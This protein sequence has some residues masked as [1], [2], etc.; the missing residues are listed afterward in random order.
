MNVD[1][2]PAQR[3]ALELW[4]REMVEATGYTHDAY[5]RLRE[6]PHTSLEKMKFFG[7]L[8]DESGVV[9]EIQKWQKEDRKSAAGRKPIFSHRAIIILFWMHKDAQ[10]SRY[11][12][13]ARTLFAQMTPE[14]REYLGLP[15]LWGNK[16]DWYCRYWRA[17]NRLLALTEPWKVDR[18][19]HASAE[20]YQAALAS[21]SQTKRDRSDWLINLLV[22]APARRLPASIRATYAGNVAI[23]GTLVEVVGKPNPSWTSVDVDRF[24]LDTMSGRYRRGGKHDGRGGKKDRAG[25]EMETVVTVPNHP[26]QPDSYPILT[27]GLAF[28]Q[29]G[30]NKVGPRIAMEFHTRG[31][32]ERGLILADR[33]Y[34]G[35]QVHR[36]QMP[37]RQMGF[38]HVF[39]YKLKESGVQGYVD[40]VVFIAGRPY[41]KW[42]PED[43]RTVRQ[44]WKAGRI[45]KETYKKRLATQAKYELKNKGRPDQDGA[46]RFRYPDLTKVACVDPA[47]KKILNGRNTPKTKATFL[48]T[49]DTAAKMRIFKHLN[50]FQHR[51]PEWKAWYGMRSHVESNNQYVKADA[52]ADLGNPEEH[53]PRGYAYQALNAALAFASSNMRRIVSFLEARAM[54]FLDTKTIQRARRRRDAEGNRLAHH[55]E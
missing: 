33:A 2:T 37:T 54:K 6:S 32:D 34:N 29:P 28:H 48:L 15:D 47:T 38:R 53:R 31:H 43:L 30:R 7:K 42:I 9:E 17:L 23:D 35:T 20:E 40:D 52:E 8:V 26:S 46:Q 41:V 4:D 22:Q 36:F 25:W 45:D 19:K 5:E 39:D 44:D 24:N 18:K 14:T 3:A 16:R 11:K 50:A 12:A 13:I 10:D 55:N 21:Y 1:L 51:G 27:T 49:P